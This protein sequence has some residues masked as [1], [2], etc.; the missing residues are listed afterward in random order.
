M[1]SSYLFTPAEL[2]SCRFVLG[3]SRE[4]RAPL[5]SDKLQLLYPGPIHLLSPFL[6]KAAYKNTLTHC[7]RHSHPHTVHMHTH[8]HTL[9]H[10][11]PT[12][13]LSRN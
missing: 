9:Q 4:N 5:Y 2:G 12:S 3:L 8:S 1:W 11:K 6:P 13:S 7:L 10:S